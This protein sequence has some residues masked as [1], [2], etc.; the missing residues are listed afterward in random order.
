M[1]SR[2]TGQNENN[3]AHNIKEGAGAAFHAAH[4]GL[5]ATE[6]FAMNAVDQTSKAIK[7]AADNMNEMMNRDNENQK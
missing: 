7:R 6:N 5:E 1:S 2:E 3:V 4:Q